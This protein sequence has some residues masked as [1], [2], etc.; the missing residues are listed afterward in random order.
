MLHEVMERYDGKKEGVCKL[1]LVKCNMYFLIF[2]PSHSVIQVDIG[3][4]P[5]I[6]TGSS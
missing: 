6:P 3:G 4:H 2:F 5:P 1:H